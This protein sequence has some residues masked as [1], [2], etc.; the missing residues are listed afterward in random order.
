MAGIS[1]IAVAILINTAMNKGKWAGDNKSAWT[2]SII[3]IE[4]ILNSEIR[5]RAMKQNAG[6]IIALIFISFTLF[7]LMSVD[8][9]WNH[10]M[11][12]AN[13]EQGRVSDLGLRFAFKK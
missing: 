5:R 2:T 1:G 9:T 8:R 6:T 12:A 10:G 13:I 7:T 3:N 11:T 4:L